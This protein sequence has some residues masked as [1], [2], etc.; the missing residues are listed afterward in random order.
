MKY[1]KMCRWLMM[2]LCLCVALSPSMAM[3][4][5]KGKVDN[6]AAFDQA[7]EA[8]KSPPWATPYIIVTLAVVLGG[9]VVC[10]PVFRHKEARPDD[11]LAETAPPK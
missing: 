3:A 5:K 4:K 9:V 7:K 11:S 10:E 8:A 2:A 6:A 1:W